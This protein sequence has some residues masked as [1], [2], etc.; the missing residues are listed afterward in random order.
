MEWGE[1]GYRMMTSVSE[2]ED[3]AA[4]INACVTSLEAL[5]TEAEAQLETAL[6]QKTGRYD[7]ESFDQASFE[8]ARAMVP[9]LSRS[10]ARALSL[11]RAIAKLRG[12]PRQDK[13]LYPTGG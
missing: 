13:V 9:T 8:A 5:L 3:W 4:R 11:A 1:K 6:A 2:R 7:K 12:E 10:H